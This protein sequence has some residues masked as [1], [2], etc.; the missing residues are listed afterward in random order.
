MEGE[1]LRLSPRIRSL[2]EDMRAEWRELD[3]RIEAFNE[4][5]IARAKTDDAAR[6]LM[7]IPGVGEAA[8]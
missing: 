5:F 8:T 6:R 4:E 7:T 1:D 3:G 2:L